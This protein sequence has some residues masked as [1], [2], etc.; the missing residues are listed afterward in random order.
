MMLSNFEKEKLQTR[1]LRATGGD[2]KW[3]EF[4]DIAVVGYQCYI[5]RVYRDG[6]LPEEAA[7]TPLKKIHSD[8]H[9]I[10]NIV[11]T[12][13][14]H[15]ARLGVNYRTVTVD[16]SRH[17]LTFEESIERRKKLCERKKSKI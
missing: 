7:T 6:M 9:T 8:R 2:T 11:A 10:D 14:E 1:R 15:C 17:N 5:A 12:R 13:Q 3:R 4:R 16:M